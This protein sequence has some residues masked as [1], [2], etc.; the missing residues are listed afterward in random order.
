MCYVIYAALI[1]LF[2]LYSDVLLEQF[3]LHAK[4]AEQQSV[5]VAEGWE[6]AL[7]LWPLLLA[8][9]IAASAL[10]YFFGRWFS[11]GAGRKTD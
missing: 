9:A 7:Q 8:S 5:M 6:I 4:L 3:D 1:L 11:A 2:V 10:T